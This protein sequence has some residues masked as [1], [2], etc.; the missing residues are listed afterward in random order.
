MNLLT[1]QPLIVNQKIKKPEIVSD[2][3]KNDGKRHKLPP[4]IKVAF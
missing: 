2:N 1:P 3:D 4:D